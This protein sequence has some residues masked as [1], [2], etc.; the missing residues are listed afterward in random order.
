MGRAAAVRAATK[1]KTD[2]AKAKNNNRY[3]KKI[4]MVIKAGGADPAVNRQL[5]NV[6]A[7]AKAANVPNDVIKRNIDKAAGADQADFK[8]SLFEFYGH[9][10]VG[11]LVNVL[12]DNDN[13]AASEVALVAKKNNLKTANS[14]SVSFNFEKKARINVNGV[15]IEEDKLLDM[16]LEAGVDDYDLRTKVDGNPENPSAE[17]DSVIYVGLNDMSSLR[18]QLKLKGFQLE[19]SL[20]QIPKAG[21]VTIND[22]DFDKNM[23]AIDAFE[24]LDDV[25]LV[26]HNIDMTGDD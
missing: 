5:A 8:E 21:Q 18:D 26:E 23:N 11:I 9:G 13:R 16:C 1:A 4:I 2:G 22:E 12:T 7:E 6:I 15:I 17:G 14:G 19:T 3:A 24:E 20:R 10:G 25:D